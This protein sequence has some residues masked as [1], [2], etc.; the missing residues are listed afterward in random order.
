M[1]KTDVITKEY[2]SKPHY[3]A[4]A[5]NSSVF[6]GNQ[7]VKADE[8]SLQ[9]MDVTE[10]GIL[11]NGKAQEI[12][13]KYRDVLKKSVLMYDNT[14]AFLLLGIEN[15]MDIHYAM[16]VKNM[17]YDA[18]NYGQQVRKTA[19]VHKQEKKLKGAEF[20]SGFAKTDK[21]MPVITLTVYYGNEH[22]DGPRCLKDMFRKNIGKEILEVVNDYKLHIIVPTE[23]ED[24]SIFKTDF[25]KAMEFIAASNNPEAVKKIRANKKFEQVYADTVLLINVCTGSNIKISKG[26]EVVDVCRGIDM[27]KAEGREEGRIETESSLWELINK[28]FIAGRTSDVELASKDIEARKRFYKEFEMME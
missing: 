1:G 6:G 8:L 25:G 13:Q 15:Q 5:F 19:E 26:E 9:E 11:L 21:I 14:T 2:M 22:W 10:L 24:F 16:P 7:V 18:L 28:L 27:I 4:D 20:L 12:V 17:I 23:I 3:F